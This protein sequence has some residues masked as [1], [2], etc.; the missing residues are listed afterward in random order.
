MYVVGTWNN[1]KLACSKDPRPFQSVILDGSLGD[2]LYED[3][4]QFFGRAKWYYDHGIPYRRGYLLY[5]SPGCGKTS[6][7]A[8]L[9]GKLKLH[10]CVLTLSNGRLDDNRLNQLLHEAPS[11]TLILLED[12]DSVFVDRNTVTK[13]S[14][15]DMRVTFSGLLNAIDG[16]ASQEG[17]LFFMTTNHIEKLDPALIRPGRC[18]VKV[19][20]K[21]AT[22][23]QIRIMFERF[24]AGSNELAEK[25]ISEIPD[26][27]VTMAQ[28]Q[29]HFMKYK[30]DPKSAVANVQKLLD[31]AHAE[32]GEEA[33]QIEQWL[34]RLGLSHRIHDFKAKQKIRVLSDI[35]NVTQHHSLKGT[36]KVNAFGERARIIEMLNGSQRMLTE[37]QMAPSMTIQR[38]F[39]QF[40]PNAS[41]ELVEKFV[42][43]VPADTV[44]IIE[45]K[46]Y[47]YKHEDPQGAM[48]NISKLLKPSTKPE[49]KQP[50]IESV[51][52]WLTRIGFEQYLAKFED[53]GILDT[54]AISKLEDQ[55]LKD[56]KLIDVKK[57]GHR[58]KM[59]R[60]INKLRKAFEKY[61][62]ESKE[63][64]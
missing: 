55:D 16:V 53:H 8:A 46:S 45:L 2:E 54:K 34:R 27:A 10:I 31:E 44:S 14:D 19:E 30:D 23:K 57:R 13:D 22:K 60:G 50:K 12:I 52:E 40:Y 47:L 49:I 62:K 20:F 26:Y 61:E 43:S 17:K 37:I 6:L 9:A 38:L 15:Q 35:Q 21:R 51:K 24:Y 64:C 18:D 39:K 5:G 28:L 11:D 33:V 25:F 29:G 32:K 1:W 42:N 7:V 36:Y 56:E 41:T 58:L 59:M 4:K 63:Y 48:Q 3:A